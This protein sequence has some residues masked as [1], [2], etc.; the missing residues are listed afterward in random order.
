MT[1]EEWLRGNNLAAMMALLQREKTSE[2]KRRL[3]ACGCWHDSW[4]SLTSEV[5]QVLRR[6]E[7]EGDGIV[8]QDSPAASSPQGELRV[9][10]YSD[11]GLVGLGLCLLSQFNLMGRAPDLDR[12][13]HLVR[14]G[15]YVPDGRICFALREVFGNPFRPAAVDP[16]WLTW[17]D[18]TVPKIAHAIYDNRDFDRMPVLADALE[19]AGCD[20]ADI[21]NH[22]RGPN[23]HVRGCWVVD[24]LLG[25][26]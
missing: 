18:G 14:N 17:N 8:V 19:D 20:N 3:F 9:R 13:E 12:S 1:E 23:V 2:R 16:S 25:K 26:G 5:R 24:L 21:L 7:L 4:S 22:C 6:F 10:S 15:R 11:V